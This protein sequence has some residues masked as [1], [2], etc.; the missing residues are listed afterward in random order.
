MEQEPQCDSKRDCIELK[1]TYSK[2]NAACQK[3]FSSKASCDAFSLTIRKYF[4]YSIWLGD[5]FYFC[6]IWLWFT[7]WSPPHSKQWRFVRKKATGGWMFV[8]Y[9]QVYFEEQSPVIFTSSYKHNNMHPKV[10]LLL[11]SVSSAVA[12]GSETGW[13][14]PFWYCQ[15]T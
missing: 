3:C 7:F 11:S 4:W 1:K 8:Q 13:V 12:L 5:A 14:P 15:F 6:L 9:K 10:Q 2:T